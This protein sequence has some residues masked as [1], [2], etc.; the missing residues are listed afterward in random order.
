MASYQHK[1]LGESSREIRLV[2]LQPGHRSDPIQVTLTHALLDGDIAYD[3]LSYAWGDPNITLPIAIDGLLFQ[4]TVNLESALRHLRLPA[5][6]RVIWIDAICIHQT[7]I[8]ERDQQV[9]RMGSV[10]DNAKNV[11]VWLGPEADDSDLAMDLL[12][13]KICDKLFGQD[14]FAR[15]H[16]LI[17]EEGGNIRH[18]N[19]VVKLFD[20]PWWR[21]GWTIQEIFGAGR[22]REN[23]LLHCGNSKKKWEDGFWAIRDIWSNYLNHV[24]VESDSSVQGAWWKTLIKATS[25]HEALGHA[26][27][28]ELEDWLTLLKYFETSEP[29]DKVWI[30]C[31]LTRHREPV[32]GLNL[33][34]QQSLR[35]TYTFIAQHFLHSEGSLRILERCADYSDLP[36]WVPDWQLSEA[37][38]VSGGK[39]DRFKACGPL[40]LFYEILENSYLHLKGFNIGCA[41]RFPPL[42]DTYIL[43][44]RILERHAAEI[45]STYHITGEPSMNALI[46]TMFIDMSEVIH[47]AWE[48]LPG[49]GE[50]H[51]R[52]KNRALLFTALAMNRR[53][54]FVS[55]NGHIGL[56]P[57]A[58]QEGDMICI[59]MGGMTPFVIRPAGENY[60]LIGAC[61]VH[62]IMY[63]EAVTELEKNSQEVQD[64]I[65]V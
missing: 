1:P 15:P 42:R 38:P 48:G 63:G 30:A 39:P 13:E 43:V 27:D 46:R 2:N 37:S 56:V 47:Y 54:Y 6:P 11:L 51:D 62:G 31:L 10:Y 44:P 24:G 40:E 61:Y 33:Q 36:S 28:L 7:N 32:S 12:G 41:A 25:N 60:K 3:A 18:L 20:R 34:Y 52:P 64:F 26:S 35:E 57:E 29:K 59:F 45:G 5:E 65:L 4:V 22:I 58:A 21:R 17:S 9:R 49:E 23:V 55:A 16:S 50:S 19:A 53:K 14:H 8:E